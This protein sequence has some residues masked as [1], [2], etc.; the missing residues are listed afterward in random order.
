MSVFKTDNFCVTVPPEWKAFKVNE[1]VLQICKDGKK[2]SDILSKPYMQLNFSGDAYMLPPSKDGYYDVTD[3]PPRQ[4]GKYTWQGFECE[5]MG[6]R[7]AMLWTGEGKRQ[8][9]VSAN[10]ETPLGKISMSDK[11]VLEILA[12]VSPFY[13]TQTGII[14]PHIS[15]DPSAAMVVTSETLTTTPKAENGCKMCGAAF[16]DPG[17]EFCMNCGAKR[18]TK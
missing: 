18:E 4:F 1:R 17:A 12:S 2:D 10:L 5:S 8:F 13:N 6:F 15:N 16:L 9:Q 11:D 3:I 7:V 14:P